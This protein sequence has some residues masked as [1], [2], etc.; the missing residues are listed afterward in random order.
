MAEHNNCK[1]YRCK[2]FKEKIEPTYTPDGNRDEQS[3]LAM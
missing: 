2:H 1:S 3:D